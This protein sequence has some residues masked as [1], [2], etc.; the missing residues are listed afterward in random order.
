MTVTDAAR[1]KTVDPSTVRRWCQRGLIPAELHGKT[2]WIT[3]VAALK[4][5]TPPPPGHKSKRA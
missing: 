5:F 2:W 3:D 4:Q 1:L